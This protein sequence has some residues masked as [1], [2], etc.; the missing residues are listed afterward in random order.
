[1]DSVFSLDID[2]RY[3]YADYLTW[4]DDKRRELVDG[5][6][7][8]MSTPFTI[9]QEIKLNL[10]MALYKIVKRH[11]GKYEVFFSPLDVCLPE[12]GKIADNEI[13]NVVQPDLFIVCDRSKIK[14]RCCLGAPDF[15]AEIQSG[16]TSYYDLTEKFKL[17]E[18]FGV[19]EYWTVFPDEWVNVFIL[20]PDGKYSDAVIYD[21]Y[22]NAPVHIFGG[23]EI[24][25]KDVFE[26]LTHGGLY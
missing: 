26:R 3:T 16:D 6:V 19:R 13:Y 20:Q 15:V 21:K 1:M 23:V 7:K 11:K 4:F 9:H 17:Y 8:P 2:K 25:L 24:K 10:G 14:E 5:F 22:R 18:A 12:N